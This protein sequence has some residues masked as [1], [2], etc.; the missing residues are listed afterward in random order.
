MQLDFS[1]FEAQKKRT[2]SFWRRIIRFFSEGKLLDKDVLVTWIKTNVGEET[3]RE[4]FDRTGFIINI[5]VSGDSHEQ[6]RVLN[7]LTSPNVLIW[8]AASASCSVPFIFG[9]TN[10]LCKNEKG[11]IEEWLPISIISS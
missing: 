1:V 3:F 4:A 9:E 7:Y 11:L 6:Y 5:V 2:G 10:I 8:S